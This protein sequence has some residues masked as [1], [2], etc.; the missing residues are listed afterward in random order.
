MRCVDWNIRLYLLFVEVVGN[1]LHG[2]LFVE[3]IMWELEHKIEKIA[4]GWSGKGTTKIARSILKR[5]G[6][7]EAWRTVGK[8]G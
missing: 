7:A 2:L 8:N 3:K 4:Y 6:G 1:F 5:L